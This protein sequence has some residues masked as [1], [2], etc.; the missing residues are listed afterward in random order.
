ML[1]L[2]RKI[3]FSLTNSN[4]FQE[5]RTKSFWWTQLVDSSLPI[6]SRDDLSRSDRQKRKFGL[7]NER[8]LVDGNWWPKSTASASRPAE[9]IETNEIPGSPSARERR[10]PAVATDGNNNY[11]SRNYCIRDSAAARVADEKKLGRSH[12]LFSTRF[13]PNLD[14]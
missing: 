7:S 5:S 10:L 14:F 9:F 3:D 1:P 6:H 2:T 8:G 4:N 12:S 13:R 11:I